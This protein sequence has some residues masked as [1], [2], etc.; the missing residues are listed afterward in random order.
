MA[1]FY[2]RFDGGTQTDL[3]QEF[4]DKGTAFGADSASGA[5]FRDGLIASRSAVTTDVYDDLDLS[6]QDGSKGIYFPPDIVTY[7]ASTTYASWS[8]A[9]T[10]SVQGI[11]IDEFGILYR[12][13]TPGNYSL[14]PTAS[15]TSSQ[16]W[17]VGQTNPN[18][19]V[20]ISYGTYISA[21]QGLK[22]ALDSISG[23]LTGGGPYVRLGNNP[24]RTLHSI[25]NDPTMSY[26]A[27]DDFTP[28]QPTVD[29]RSFYAG[30]TT[31]TSTGHIIIRITG[32]GFKNDW[33]TSAYYDISATL[34]YA[35]S[36][37]GTFGGG[38]GL[39]AT[40]NVTVPYS[41]LTSSVSSNAFT[42]RWNP[43]TLSKAVGTL[44]DGQSSDGVQL[45]LSVTF[46]DPLITSSLGTAG[47]VNK[48]SGEN[49]T[50]N[51]IPIT[52]GGFIKIGTT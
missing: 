28:G 32:S 16:T 11:K 51:G 23:L 14:R 19:P 4:F 39:A 27:W 50:V 34:R 30:A 35:T 15:I 45:N 21:S 36:S 17:L 12:Y 20:Q 24:S 18:D 33:N 42:Y 1:R 31:T 41:E 13:G 38:S 52:N 3:D 29:A 37:G 25:W 49:I 22:N 46:R 43:G 26:L 5:Q 7:P 40:L 44:Q 48:N 10:S 9:Y 6:N 47:T 8:T 2:C